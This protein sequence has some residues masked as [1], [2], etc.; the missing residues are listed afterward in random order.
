MS[1]SLYFRTKYRA[2]IKPLGEIP[3]S[4]SLYAKDLY[5]YFTN[6]K[7]LH[8]ILNN[9]SVNLSD[10]KTN[11]NLTK[12]LRTKLKSCTEKNKY[13][14]LQKLFQ[15][16]H[17]NL[18]EI[19]YYRYIR[20]KESIE[21]MPNF[22]I[23][24][25]KLKKSLSTQ[26][27]TKII[28][29]IVIKRFGIDYIKQLIPKILGLCKYLSIKT[30]YLKEEVKAI[31][32]TFKRNGG[33]VINLKKIENKINST[34]IHVVAI[35]D[36]YKMGQVWLLPYF[37]GKLNAFINKSTRNQ[38]IKDLL[39]IMNQSY[40]MIDSAV[41][42]LVYRTKNNSSSSFSRFFMQ[43]KSNN[44]SGNI[45]DIEIFYKDTPQNIITKEVVQ[46][47]QK[48]YN[49]NNQSALDN[50]INQS[51]LKNPNNQSTLKN[52]NNLSTLK[53]PNNLS[54]LD[55]QINQSTLKNPINQSAF[56][57]G[58]EPVS[59]TVIGTMIAVIATFTAA[60]ISII[61]C[62]NKKN[63]IPLCIPIYYTVTI[64]YFILCILL[65]VLEICSTQ[66]LGFISSTASQFLSIFSNS[67]TSS[68]SKK[69]K[70][71]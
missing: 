18:K 51:A 47:F 40:P 35:D 22:K 43:K 50:P 30:G 34:K 2:E 62:L 20:D 29:H 63:D 49:P 64:L 55:N 53:N 32:N 1:L 56:Q 14:D 65:C 44:T 26:Y 54:T 52:P 60:T 69:N 36:Y 48:S 4:E 33:N 5:I 67:P 15:E 68:A 24:L 10:V 71:D 19:S 6:R 12:K 41:C 61:Y 58:G 31:N 45:D 38:D 27:L 9:L 37:K 28:A 13:I 39:K 70:K 16:F 23:E 66:E 8:V 25:E 46:I 57:L 42:L 17:K 59:S 7:R 11:N 21:M 3:N